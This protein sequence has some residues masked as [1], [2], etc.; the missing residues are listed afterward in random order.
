MNTNE[1][2]FRTDDV[3]LAA[4]LKIYFPILEVE[5]ERTAEGDWKCSWIFDE[6]DELADAVTVYIGGN[7]EE[8]LKEYNRNVAALKRELISEQR[9]RRAADRTFA[10]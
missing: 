8:N 2:R 10:G 1:T 7:A 9:S 6:S 3:T 4:Y 5:W